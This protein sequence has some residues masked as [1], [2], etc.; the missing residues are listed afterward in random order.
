MF[1]LTVIAFSVIIGVLFILARISKKAA[2]KKA[3]IKK[4][5]ER[6]SRLMRVVNSAVFDTQFSCPDAMKKVL[7][8][9]AL[10][11]CSQLRESGAPKMLINTPEKELR[12]QLAELRLKE[13]ESSVRNVIAAA[14]SVSDRSQAQQGI[15]R[16]LILL[17]K[18]AQKSDIVA[19]DIKEANTALTLSGLIILSDE[20]LERGNS[21]LDKG[22]IG[23]A[24]SYF[25]NAIKKIQSA[26]ALVPLISDRY[27]KLK[28]GLD[29][30]NLIIAD[31]TNHAFKTADDESGLARMFGKE[32]PG[33]S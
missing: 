9:R 20:L 3:M 7:L 8:H 18:E 11:S 10:S 5:V 25:E 32:K 13:G 1:Y 23:S 16:M 31:E 24:R 15:H 27:Q 19:S 29:E 14:S 28:S 12:E 6:H 2:E 22:E 4:L 21:A 33:W 26:P 17:K 30:V